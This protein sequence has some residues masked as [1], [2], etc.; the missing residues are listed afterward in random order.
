MTTASLT[1]AE[2]TATGN[3]LPVVGED[4]RE[5][6]IAAIAVIWV[7]FAAGVYLPDIGRGFIKDDFRWVLDGAAALDHPVSVFVSGWAGNFFRPLVAFSFGLDHA[8]Y[9]LWARGYG[10][11]NLALYVGCV[12]AVYG[13]L[14]QLGISPVAAAGGAFAWAV[15]PS[16][17]DMAVLWLSGRTSLLMT[18]FSCSA[19]TLFLRGRRYWATLFFA[20]ALLSKEDALAVPLIVVGA[21]WWGR[22]PSRPWRADLALM[23]IV[24]A[25]YL[26]LRSHTQAI[27]MAT[28]PD[29]YRLTWKPLGLLVNGLHYLDRAGTS[30][31]VLL[32]LTVIAYGAQPR[33]ELLKRTRMPELACLWFVAGLIITIAVPI[34][35]SLYAVFPSVAAAMVYASVLDSLRLPWHDTR[36]DRWLVCVYAS[37]LFLIPAYGIRN[38]RW[39]EPARVSTRTMHV[40]RSSPAVIANAS[41]IVFDDEPVRFSNF[42]AALGG[43]EA[44]ALKLFTGRELPGHVAEPGMTVSNRQSGSLT[45]RLRHGQVTWASSLPFDQS[46]HQPLP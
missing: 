46:P 40:L 18:L 16:G 22:A 44:P 38:D 5:P 4:T 12:F 43:V 8:A 6:L 13:L 30:T 3:E 37:V 7:L 15:N 23:M 21:R 42:A 17:L 28:A 14:R 32:V 20:A 29:F 27:T 2:R 10:F 26:T 24:T 1:R 41:A 36:R 31:A 33:W 35:S 11:T 25:A 45:L 9:G 39:V 34:R 19:V